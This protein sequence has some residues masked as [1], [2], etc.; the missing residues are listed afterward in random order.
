MLGSP[1]S[2]ANPLVAGVS[3][4]VQEMPQQSQL[5][6]AGG[7][8]VDVAALG[9]M[10]PVTRSFPSQKSLPEPGAR[11]DHRQGALGI[12]R[13]RVQGMEV[14]GP[15][16]RRGARDRLQVVEQANRS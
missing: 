16:E 13:P 10:G 11:C 1:L 4:A 7:R 5:E 9:G 6:L 2:G 3:E 15:Q 12:G 14:L 8:E